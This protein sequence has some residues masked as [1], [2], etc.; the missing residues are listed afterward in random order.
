MVIMLDALARGLGKQLARHRR[1]PFLEAAMAASALVAAADGKIT[2]SETSRV[3]DIVRHLSM[4]K[5]FDVHESLD[6]FQ[7]YIA[8]IQEDAAAGKAQALEAVANGAKD[9]ELSVLLVRLCAAISQADGEFHPTER[10]VIVEICHVLGL[11]PEDLD[12]DTS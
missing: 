9:H 11:R 12:I 4:L 10:D 1:R 8:A 5:V 7:D 3:D 2:F 6:L